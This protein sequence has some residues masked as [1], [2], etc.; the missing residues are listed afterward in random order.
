MKNE[1]SEIDKKFKQAFP[2]QGSDK[3]SDFVDVI[4]EANYGSRELPE[5][6]PELFPV[7]DR[8]QDRPIGEAA[9]EPDRNLIKPRQLKAK[10]DRFDMCDPDD[11]RRLEKINNSI[12][13]DGWLLAREEWVHTKDGGTFVIVKYLESK[14]VKKKKDPSEP[15]TNSDGSKSAPVT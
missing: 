2:G 10:Y 7:P 15:T 4:Q 9:P 6:I 8:I 5:E 3:S 14:K 12:L 11:I 1:Q 13:Q